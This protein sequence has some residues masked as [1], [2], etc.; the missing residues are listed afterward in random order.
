[1]V[2]KAS[3]LFTRPQQIILIALRIYYEIT[4]ISSATT[5]ITGL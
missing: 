5:F 1:M 4:Y 2:I 3:N